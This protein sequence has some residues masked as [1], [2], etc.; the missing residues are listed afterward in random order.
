VQLNLL[1][2]DFVY[3]LYYT[4]G[5]NEIIKSYALIKSDG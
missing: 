5:F 2:C 4:G 3:Q 1:I